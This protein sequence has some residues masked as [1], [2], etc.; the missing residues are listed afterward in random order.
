MTRLFVGLV[1]PNHI[2]QKYSALKTAIAGIR[3]Q[4]PENFHLTLA[5]IGE[6]DEETAAKVQAALRTVQADTFKLSF[7]GVGTFARKKEHKVL[8]AGCAKSKALLKL[9]EKVDDALEAAGLQFDKKEFTPHVTLA[10]LNKVDKEQLKAFLDEHKDFATPEFDVLEF[11]LYKS[12]GTKDGQ[13]YTAVSVYP[14]S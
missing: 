1:I 14:L 6:A 5:F 10:A 7:N 4:K 12:T 2:T 13:V 3:W 9:K 8:W 11:I